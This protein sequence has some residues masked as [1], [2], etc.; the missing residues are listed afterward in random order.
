[1]RE[2]IEFHGPATIYALKEGPEWA[3]Y[4]DPFSVAGEGRTADDAVQSAIR[5]LTELLG[6]LAAEI[7]QHGARNVEVLCPLKPSLRR[8]A[9]RRVQVLL[10]AVNTPAKE[11][12]SPASTNIRPFSKRSVKSLLVKSAGIAVVPPVCL[13]V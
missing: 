1:M 12:V 11:P 9:K 3:A 7:R 4:V 10:V 13:A 6:V 2:Q 5:N 8:K